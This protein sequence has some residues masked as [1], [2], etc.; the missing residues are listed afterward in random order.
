M[1]K[2]RLKTKTKK[3]P[4]KNENKTQALEIN[5][6]FYFNNKWQLAWST[7]AIKLLKQTNK[8][9]ILIESSIN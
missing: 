5:Y 8:T 6:S 2:T 7:A 1:I 3:P 4:K 9:K